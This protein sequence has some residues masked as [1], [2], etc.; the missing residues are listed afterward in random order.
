MQ[1]QYLAV[2]PREGRVSRN[3]FEFQFM[4]KYF[5]TPREGRVSRNNVTGMLPFEDMVTTP[6]KVYV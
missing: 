5:V 6:R 1:R 2:T 4:R 3:S